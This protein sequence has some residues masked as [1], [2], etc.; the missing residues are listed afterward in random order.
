MLIRAEKLMEP[1]QVLI[2]QQE[3]I[4]LTECLK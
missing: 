4:M 2:H 1:T 3:I